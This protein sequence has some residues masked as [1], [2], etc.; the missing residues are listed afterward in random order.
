MRRAIAVALLLSACSE[1]ETPAPA[2]VDVPEGPCGHALVVM[3]SDYQSSSVAIVG[4]DGDVLSSAIVSSASE[5]TGLSVPLS[6]DAVLPT[7][8]TEA[9]EVL[10]LDREQAVLT[11]LDPVTATVT[12]QIELA[13]GFNGANPQDVLEIGPSKLYV[14]RYGANANAGSEPFDQGSDVL[15]VDRE[16]EEILGRIDLAAMMEGAAE[17]ILPNPSRMV[18]RGDQAFLLLSAYSKSFAKSD[19]GRVAV[20]DTETDEA[21]SFAVVTGMRGCSALALAPSGD[22][23]AV[24]CSGTFAGDA[25]PSLEDSGVVVF[26]AGA[27]GDIDEEQRFSAEDLGGDPLSFSLSFASDQSLLLATFGRKNAANEQE[28]PDRLLALDLSTGTT[29]EIARSEK[30]P[31]TIGEV[32]C[33][34]ACGV[35]FAA[36]AED[37]GVLRIPVDQGEL[38][39]PRLVPINDGIGL[40]PRYLGAY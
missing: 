11:V 33:A 23:V 27:E 21:L 6:K 16:S 18:R 35:C 17:D 3:N 22:R 24:G 5:T 25:V 39:S 9:G 38:G 4:Y 40:P 26:R 2:G 31:F 37:L 14:S 7:T 32:H 19:D 1:P 34:P 30:A 10:L 20:I 13:T 28:R 29:D 8:R 36:D 15:V 12:S